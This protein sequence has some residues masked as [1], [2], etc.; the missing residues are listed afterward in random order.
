MKAGEQMIHNLLTTLGKKGTNALT[1]AHDIEIM[2][3]EEKEKLL[4]S[5]N[6]EDVGPE[7]EKKFWDTYAKLMG[8]YMMLIDKLEYL[9]G[10]MEEY[11]IEVEPDFETGEY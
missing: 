10:L 4:L 9:F 8:A 2:I 11:S 6:C 5:L 3:M 1:E 7:Q